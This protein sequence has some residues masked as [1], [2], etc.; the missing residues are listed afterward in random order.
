LQFEYGAVSFTAPLGVV[1]RVRLEGLE[2]DWSVPT[3]Q[4]T[5]RYTNLRPGRYV[6]RVSACNWGGNWC[7]PLEVPFKIIQNRQAQEAQQALERERIAKEVYRAT[8]AR[9]EELNGQL[10]VA[11]QA[12]EVARVKAEELARLRSGFVATVS[13]ELR[14]PLTAIVGYGELLRMHWTRLD[15]AARLDRVGRI[16]TAANRQQRLVEE[17]LLLSRLEIGV[18]APSLETA[19]L[20]PLVDRAADEVR[21]GYHGQ[22]IEV[23]GP[24]DIAVMVDPDRAVQILVNVID[25]AAKYSPDG[26]SIEVRW[27]RDNGYAVVRVCDH[28]TGI[29]ADGRDHLFTRFG[30]VSGSQA[31]PGHV[32]T[33]LGLHL[34]RSLAQA[35]GGG[36]E[37]ESTDANGSVF[38]L[39]LPLSG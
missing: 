24:C 12:A 32:G 9:L 18:L 39:T 10:A 14:T 23:E 4:R 8:A 7:E 17:L 28:G 1:Y 5:R 33:G 38:R 13:H 27:L 2:S 25:N 6:F 35:M 30:R 34:G 3:A 31:R 16:V 21:A 11:Q 26:A 20:Q 37:L 22:C 36:L 15:D 29:P 19:F